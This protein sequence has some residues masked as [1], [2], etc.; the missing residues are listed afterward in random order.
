MDKGTQ[1]DSCDLFLGTSNQYLTESISTTSL[2]EMSTTSTPLVVSGT[3]CTSSGQVATP[4]RTSLVH[5][6]SEKGK[7]SATPASAIQRK[8]KRELTALDVP[9]DLLLTAPVQNTDDG[10]VSI[11]RTLRSTRPSTSMS[12][13]RNRS[14][15]PSQRGDEPANLAR[16][17]PIPN[18]VLQRARFG[19]SFSRALELTDE[20]ELAATECEVE[21][22][23]EKS[24]T[25]SSI[26]MSSLRNKSSTPNQQ[27][28]SNPAKRLRT[29]SATGSPRKVTLAAKKA[30]KSLKGETPKPYSKSLPTWPSET[31]DE[32]EGFCEQ[33]C[34]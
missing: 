20:Q 1:T 7:F 18:R 33:V 27:V 28:M 11:V 26:S 22:A 4:I 30:R 19:S 34:S 23:I 3:S 9:L 13:L 31:V 10:E 17:L 12:S 14:S 24:K 32:D 2:T 5:K 8:L 16:V 21:E 6:A 15:T 25:Q 29:E